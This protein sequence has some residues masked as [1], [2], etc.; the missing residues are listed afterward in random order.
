MDIKP[1]RPL[2]G[3]LNRSP[4]YYLRVG[5]PSEMYEQLC[6]LAAQ[7]HI[8]LAELI[9]GILDETMKD[10]NIVAARKVSDE[11]IALLS[12]EVIDWMRAQEDYKVGWTYNDLDIRI[13]LAIRAALGGRG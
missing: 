11:W 8:T 9:R 7:R 1:G 10:G 12:A 2:K 6:D 3:A 4:L 5:I 13:R